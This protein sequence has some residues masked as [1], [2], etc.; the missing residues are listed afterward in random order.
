[1]NSGLVK[2]VAV[3]GAA[4]FG[5]EQIANSRRLD[6]LNRAFLRFHERIRQEQLGEREIL[7][8]RRAALTERLNDTLPDGLRARTFD[9]GSYAMQTGVKPLSGEFDIDIGLILECDKGQFS[10]AVE[11]KQMV[12]DVLLQGSRR[13]RIRRSCVTVDYTKA[14][15]GDYHVDIAVYAIGRNGALFLA[16][17]KER[18]EARLRVWQT[19]DPEGLTALV[20]RRFAGE[21]IGQFRRCIRYLKRWKHV[22]FATPAPY[23]I[24]L[25]I[26]SYHWFEPK[27]GGLILDQPNDFE[28]LLNLTRRMLAEFQGKRLKVLLPVAPAVA[29]ME[30]MT[31]KQQAEFRE[32]LTS[33]ATALE[34]ARY[35]SESTAALDALQYQLGD[36]FG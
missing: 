28:A 35:A 2:L 32:K 6:A 26:A 11:A 30:R 29:L 33:L 16:K 22:N 7:R 25:T 3:A 8:E 10:D 4:I 24:A 18:S 1:M 5:F 17:G 9:Q 20:N 14:G 23:S 34:Y 12:R 27:L 13:V 21:A 36:E 19:A 15:F 31:E